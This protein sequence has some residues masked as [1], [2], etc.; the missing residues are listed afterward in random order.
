[1]RNL[2][3][4]FRQALYRNERNYIAY[5][6]ITLADSTELNL[7]NT[8]IWSGGFSFEDSVSD[9]DTFSAL[10]SVIIGSATLIINNIYEEFS[11][12]DFTNATVV[13]SLAMQFTDNTVEKFKIGTYTVDDT[14]YNGATIRLSLLDNLEQF[15]RPYS[16][17]N[18]QYPAT[19]DAIVRDLCTTCGVSLGTVDFPHKSQVIN[20]RPA[21][22]ALTCR[23][24]LSDVATIAGCFVKCNANGAI[25]LRWFD[26]T[27]LD[28]YPVGL[29]GGKFD[30]ANPYATGD[31][32]DGG[33]FNPWNTGTEYDSN[34]ETINSNIHY[35]TGINS[36]NI[37]VDD[38]VITG[39]SIV[40]ADETTNTD[41]TYNATGSTPGYVI[42]IIN[43]SLISIETAQTIA[44]WLGTQLIGL[45]FRKL[46][47]SHLDD[48]AIES[49]DIA[50][51][52]DRKQNE[53]P[54]LVT[55][56]TFTIGGFQTIVCGSETPSR[57]SATR[58]SQAVK[59]FIE[60]RKLLKAE[61]TA[62]EL[63]LQDLTTRLNG[64]SGLYS[65]QET[66]QSGTIYYLHDKPRLADSS[67]IW[68]MTSE[69]WGVSTDGGTTWNA[70]MTVDGNVIANILSA[71]GVNADWIDTG[72]LIVRDTQNN[73]IFK[74]DIANKQILIKGENITLGN[75]SLSNAISTAQSNAETNAV[76]TV[77]N[78]LTQQDIFNRLTNNGAAQ[79]LALV[80][81]QLYISFSYAQGGTLKLG[82]AGNVNG[83]MEVYDASNQLVT[84]INRTGITTKS[85]TASDYV[86]VDSAG[87][88]R[89]KVP[90]KD[91]ENANS[92]LGYFDVSDE[93]CE[94]Q[95]ATS[96]VHI[97]GYTDSWVYP[98]DPDTDEV[99]YTGY[100][101][102]TITPKT[103]S[104]WDLYTPMS[105]P[106][107]YLSHNQFKLYSASGRRIEF[108]NS[109]GYF[110]GDLSCGGTKNRIVDTE[111]YAQRKFYCYETA[112]PY[113]GDVGEGILDDTGNCRI[114][115]DPIIAEAIELLGYQVFLQSYGN[116]PVYVINRQSG[117]F[118]V[119]GTANESFGWELKAKQKDYSQYRMETTDL[120]FTDISQTD[121]VNLAITHIAEI[122]AERIN[123]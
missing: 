66:T 43:N 120:E 13:L 122:N 78:G 53:Y 17:S 29:D 106:G 117:Y 77:R 99:L 110:A 68:K 55:R 27:T 75:V 25:E 103:P 71:I 39:L 86:Y 35:I 18:L 108:T 113:F 21:D 100:N 6:D 50:I 57:N 79:G 96:V 89:F 28:S 111:D 74:A 12:Y 51:A 92:Y 80:N 22:E 5:A 32:A 7:T 44:D 91:K 4:K 65:T 83:L 107:A 33:S 73:V 95:T 31:T 94:I 49:G 121:Y 76:T 69:A 30:S 20:N 41:I 9:D 48:P 109:N 115:I 1:M 85:L 119:R 16:N 10:G 15:D 112:S 52:I 102:I 23:E 123:A 87:G 98:I 72:A 36:Q 8:E 45:T 56:Q 82:G 2:S 11:D 63:A 90:F 40:V 104:V 101:G 97:G 3:T 93:G 26:R 116:N 46:N 37:C 105:Q 88:S 14:S 67:I 58:Y 118:D 19:L 38:T 24:V 61:K 70:G 114:W 60:S 64:K 54:V 81:G 34:L 84:Q 62:R 47:V 59:N 42:Q